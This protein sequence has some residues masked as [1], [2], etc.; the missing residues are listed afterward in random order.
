M[1]LPEIESVAVSELDSDNSGRAELVNKSINILPDA[2]KEAFIA[3]QQVN[4]D[5]KKKNADE[6]IRNAAK[7]AGRWGDYTLSLIFWELFLLN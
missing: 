6:I 5:Y 4:L 1:E 3:K 7:I 2:Y